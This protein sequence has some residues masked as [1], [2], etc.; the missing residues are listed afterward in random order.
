MKHLAG[1]SR[2]PAH[3]CGPPGCNGRLHFR[4]VGAALLLAN[5]SIPT[6]RG[7]LNFSIS[8]NRFPFDKPR[9]LFPRRSPLHV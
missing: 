1:H 9:L 5:S 3:P 4:I 2:Y 7:A 6:R 8:V